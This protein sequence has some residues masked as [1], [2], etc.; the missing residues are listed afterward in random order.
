MEFTQYDVNIRTYEASEMCK[1]PANSTGFWAPGYMYD[2]V[3]KDLK[4][5]TIYFYSYG[6][7]KVINQF[8]TVIR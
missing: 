1:D 8:F 2:S 5:N 7:E 6:T 4:P 3:L